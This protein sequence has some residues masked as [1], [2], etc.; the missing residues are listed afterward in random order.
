[1]AAFD[2]SI[3]QVITR[4]RSLPRGATAV[5]VG[6]LVG[7]LV[8]SVLAPVLLPYGANE[9]D[10]SQTLLPPVPFSGSSA[11]HPFGT[12]ELGRDMLSRLIAGGG[13]SLIVSFGTVLIAGVF[14]V[15]LGMLAGYVGRWVDFVVQTWIEVQVTFP[16]MLMAILFL[17]LVGASRTALIAFLAFVGW[18]VFAR[19]A[20]AGVLSERRQEYV[21]SARAIGAGHTRVLVR[22]I[23][24]VLLPALGVIA[25]LE[26]A[27][28]MLAE[29]ALSFLGLG[30]RPPDVSWGLMMAEGRDQMV[31]AWW[32]VV[33]P[34]LAIVASVLSAMTLA[35]ASRRQVQER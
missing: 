33:L 8:V 34:G 29:S 2:S 14:G 15:A 11:S 16:G 17:A 31:D 6:F 1:V 28:T 3:G 26:I 13:T 32:L 19:A 10:L 35:E 23:G 5:A 12:D 25:A 9:Q 21:R 20:R 18:M 27:Q 22:H 7:L 4:P 24:P 30:V